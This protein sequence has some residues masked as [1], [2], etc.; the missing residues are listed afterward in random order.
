MTLGL[1]GFGALAW[2]EALHG[3]LY[4]YDFRVDALMS[5][6]DGDGWPIHL[7]GNVFSMPGFG[8][9]DTLAV[10]VTATW[11]WRRGQRDLAVWCV[12]GGLAAWALTDT[13]KPTFGRPLPPFIAQRFPHGYGFPSGHTMGATVTVGILLFMATQSEITLRRL[14]PAAAGAAWWRA[15]LWWTGIS[16]SVGIARILAQHH[17]ASDVL[18]AWALGVATVSAVLLLARVPRPVPESPVISAPSPGAT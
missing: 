5:R 7:V 4:Q 18:G 12:V 11:L 2:D 3:A 10:A 13:L 8:P 9:V 1:L 14:G 6:L 15:V 17:W 16:L